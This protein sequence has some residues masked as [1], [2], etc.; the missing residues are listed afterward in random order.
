MVVT[1]ADAV[2]VPVAATT[3]AA[4]TAASFR[5]TGSCCQGRQ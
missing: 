3:I 4:A 1:W 2:A 5:V